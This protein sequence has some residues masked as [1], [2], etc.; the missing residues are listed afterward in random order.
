MDTG[1]PP[2]AGMTTVGSKTA[3]RAEVA[4]LPKRGAAVS[5]RVIT[6]GVI[7]AAEGQPESIDRWQV[8]AAGHATEAGV[9][10]V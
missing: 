7:P 2:A 10:G 1:W 5:W 4:A 3:M 9:S 8:G 6:N